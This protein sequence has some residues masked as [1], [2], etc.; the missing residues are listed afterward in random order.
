MNAGDFLFTEAQIIPDQE[1]YG[2]KIY[3]NPASEK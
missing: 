2:L 3:P 1:K